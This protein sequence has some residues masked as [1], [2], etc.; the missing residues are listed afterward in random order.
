V[1]QEIR[2]MLNKIA[3]RNCAAATTTTT[4]T[5]TTATTSSSTSTAV[6]INIWNE[7]YLQHWL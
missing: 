3:N 6:L 1:G 5:T 7:L 2:E 4:T